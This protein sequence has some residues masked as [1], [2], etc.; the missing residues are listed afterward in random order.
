V[1]DTEWEEA[2]RA[3]IEKSGLKPGQRYRHYKTKAIYVIRDIGIA[4]HDKEPMVSYRRADDDSGWMWMR[5]LRVFTGRAIAENT[6]VPR[7]A[8]VED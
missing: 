4:E 7:F 2:A 6:L 1:S 3:A 5:Y 8:L